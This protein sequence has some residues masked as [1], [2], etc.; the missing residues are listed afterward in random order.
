MANICIDIPAHLVHRL[1]LV[2]SQNLVVFLQLQVTGSEASESKSQAVR[3]VK[4]ST[5]R[6]RHRRSSEGTHSVLV[7]EWAVGHCRNIKQWVSHPE[8]GS[9][10]TCHTSRF[11]Q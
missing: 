2:F 6:R 11:K 4:D 9:H 10:K 5:W 8:D 3:Q 7:K 1:V